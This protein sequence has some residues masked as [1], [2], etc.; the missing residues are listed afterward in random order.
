M[1]DVLNRFCQYYI[2]QVPCFT[3][4]KEMGDYLKLAKRFKV[5]QNESSLI[6]YLTNRYDTIFH[7]NPPILTCKQSITQIMS[8][9]SM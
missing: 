9:S 1:R 6:V 8:S 2:V 3:V 7:Y 4:S 5:N